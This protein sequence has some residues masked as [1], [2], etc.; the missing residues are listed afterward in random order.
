MSTWL[1]DKEKLALCRERLGDLSWVMRSL[2]ETLARRA[3]KEDNC[4]GR[5]WEGRFKSQRL[6]DAGA[7]MACMAYVDLNPVRAGLAETPETSEFTSVRERFEG[8]C[9]VRSESAKVQHEE[10]GSKT[11]VSQPAAAWLTPVEEIVADEE[12][13]RWGVSLAEYL[14][15]VDVT[16]R[17]INEGK[18]GAIP[19]HLAPMLT[20]LDLRAET[21]VGSVDGYR[22][23]FQR[24]AGKR[25]KLV[26]LAKEA[27]RKWF[28]QG[29]GA[30]EL[31]AADPPEKRAV[32]IAG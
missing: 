27:G 12:F 14:E 16:G 20:R 4:K 30:K 10:S 22:S 3:N 6:C 24:I 19:S 11:A 29:R 2:N 8:E 26:K 18:R 13:G 32:R 7:V 31:Y 23:M 17:M 1:A 15:L 5:F 28:C 21:W 9:A 25:E